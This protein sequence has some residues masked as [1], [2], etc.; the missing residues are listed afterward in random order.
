MGFLQLSP[1]V[2]FMSEPCECIEIMEKTRNRYK[3]DHELQY[4]A[5]SN[6]LGKAF[7]KNYK[8]NDVFKKSS[9]KEV[10]AQ[11]KERMKEYFESW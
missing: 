8:Y 6:A 3:F 5:I 4:I 2:F 11:E 9:K 7:S 1:Q 10:D